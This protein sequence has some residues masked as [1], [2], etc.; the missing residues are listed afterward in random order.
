LAAAPPAYGDIPPGFERFVDD[1][2]CLFF[3]P[4]RI[5]TSV[6]A[7]DLDPDEVTGA[8]EEVRAKARERGVRKVKWWV[9][10]D[11]E[12][13]DLVQRLRAAGVEPDDEPRVAAMARLEE[14]EPPASDAPVVVRPVSTIEELREAEEVGLE[15]FQSSGE[16]RQAFRENIAD[17]WALQGRWVQSFAAYLDGRMVGSARSAYIEGAVL[18]IGGAVLPDARGRGAYRALVHARWEDAVERGAPALIVH[19]GS[20]SRPILERLGF[21][22]VCELEVLEDT[23]R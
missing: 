23:I 10:P 22:T 5:F 11:A 6:F 3:G 17:S 4:H 8:V 18:L 9:G 2:L 7:L 19:A 12:P 13:P 16:E 15:A 20:M 21:D 14:P 1:R